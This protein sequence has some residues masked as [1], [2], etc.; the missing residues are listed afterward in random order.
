MPFKRRGPR[1]SAPLASRARSVAGATL[2]A[3]VALVAVLIV[4]A[5]FLSSCLAEDGPTVTPSAGHHPDTTQATVSVESSVSTNVVLEPMTSRWPVGVEA[6]LLSAQ[7]G[8]YCVDAQGVRWAQETPVPQVSTTVTQRGPRVVSGLDGL[9]VSRNKEFVAYVEEGGEIVVRRMGDGHEA[10]RALVEGKG[11]TTLRAISDDGAMAALVSVDPEL[12]AERPGDQV[13]WT[14]IVVD[15]SAGTATMEDELAD[16]V[17]RRITESASGRCGLVTL[18]W[19]PEH[20]L[21]V[22]MSGDTYE[23]YLYDPAAGRLVPIPE[24]AHAWDSTPSGLVLGRGSAAPD[25]AVVWDARDGSSAPLVLDPGWAHAGAGCL[26]GDGTALALWVAQSADSGASHGW[27]VFRRQGSEWRPAGAV[28]EVD[29]MNQPP[30]LLSMDGTRAWTV[31]NQSTSSNET[32]LLSHDFTGGAWEE[33]FG[34]R[35]LEVGWAPFSFT[36]V[37]VEE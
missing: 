2:W 31:V 27:Q 33:W 24:V 26:N 18:A 3:A 25:Q 17:R 21:L 10:Y 32:V 29:W 9:A 15:L 7:T 30:T 23:T 5:V 22:G 8:L 13:P 34:S 6:V 12:E 16:V 36:A 20:K 14:V 35:D 1:T 11:H 4:A 28:A 19:L 37:M